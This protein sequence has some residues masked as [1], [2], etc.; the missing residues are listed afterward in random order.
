VT[1]RGGG[2]GCTLA[3]WGCERAR[4]ADRPQAVKLALDKQYRISLANAAEQLGVPYRTASAKLRE[5]EENLGVRLVS[6]QSG[7][8]EGGGSRLTPAGHAYGRRWRA[9]A[10]GLDAWVAAHFAAAFGSACAPTGIG[11]RAGPCHVLCS[12]RQ[13]LAERIRS[14]AGLQHHREAACSD[15]RRAAVTWSS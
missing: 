6:G 15:A 10:D 13:V 1:W 9:F 4:R 5:I 2:W 12:V 7:G 3:E 11:V 14:T 8:A